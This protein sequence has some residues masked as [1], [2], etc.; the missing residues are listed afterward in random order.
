MPKQIVSRNR[1]VHPCWSLLC[2]VF[3]DN[4]QAHLNQADAYLTPTNDTDRP[5]LIEEY[6]QLCRIVFLH[7]LEDARELVWTT[8]KE[9][10]F[11]LLSSMRVKV[12][13]W[14]STGMDLWT[15]YRP[16]FS[17]SSEFCTIFLC[18][19]KRWCKLKVYPQ[20][21]PYWWTFL[22]NCWSLWNAGVRRTTLHSSVKQWSKPIWR[23][24]W[25]KWNKW[26]IRT[27]WI[28]PIMK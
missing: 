6:H 5:L 1:S 18:C 24:S 21:D 19:L 13:N 15:N 3:D 26:Q 20:R 22:D 23:C 27:I 28:S 4:L 25:P 12:M 7:R 8:V 2:T 14:E 9:R 17:L 11:Y 10:S 16:V